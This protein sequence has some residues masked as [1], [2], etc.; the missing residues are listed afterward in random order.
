MLWSSSYGWT[1]CESFYLI[2]DVI[3]VHDCHR[4]VLTVTG[5]WLQLI[6]RS[7]AGIHHHVIQIIVLR[8]PR[9]SVRS[10]ADI[11]F[12]D[13]VLILPL[14]LSHPIHQLLWLSLVTH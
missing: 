13:P 2:P 8:L 11:C 14:I 7:E 3:H 5:S 4:F 10:E 9:Q 6:T 1:D 12:P